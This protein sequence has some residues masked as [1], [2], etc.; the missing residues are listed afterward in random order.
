MAEMV[1]RRTS[2]KMIAAER[3]E[4]FAAAIP[5]VSRLQ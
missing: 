2:A 4:A 1:D 3:P 5:E